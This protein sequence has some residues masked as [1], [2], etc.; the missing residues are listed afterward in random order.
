MP[1]LL[2][3][4]R[5][6]LEDEIDVAKQVASNS[7]LPLSNGHR[8]GE[9]GK[10]YQYAFLIDT[11]LN[12]PDGAPGELVLPGKPPFPVTIVSVEGLRI[13]ISVE[14]D[15]GQFVPNA[16]LQ[17]NLA[18]LM[19]R[20]IE[21]IE[22]RAL[23]ENPAGRRM[24]GLE[25]VSG[26]PADLHAF[27]NLNDEQRQALAS[28]LGRNLTVIWGP[29]GTGKTHTIGT[30]VEQ[31]F[32]A[33]RTVLVVSHTNTAVDQAI[34]HVAKSMASQLREGKVIRVGDIR[35][36]ELRANYPDVHIKYQVERQSRELVRQREL[37]TVL[38]D[39][40][41]DDLER[42][43]AKLNL[44]DW[45]KGAV[46][47]IRT[48][49]RAVAEFAELETQLA[50][51]RKQLEALQTEH[52]D[53]LQLQGIANLILEFRA[54]LAVKRTEQL[55]LSTELS[56][57]EPRLSTAQ[58]ALREQQ[59][60]R[61]IA[62]R[63]A[64]LKTEKTAYPTAS[65]QEAAIGV[66]SLKLAQADE[67]LEL[68]KVQRDEVIALLAQ[69]SNMVGF[70]RFLRGLPPPDELKSKAADLANKTTALEAEKLA[71]KRAFWYTSQKLGRIYELDAEL[72]SHSDIDTPATEAARAQTAEA[73]VRD[74]EQRK[75][76][77]ENRLRVVNSELTRLETEICRHASVLSDDPMD[78][79]ATVSAKLRLLRDL[80]AS[81]RHLSARANSLRQTTL[82][83]L[84]QLFD[85]TRQWMDMERV[86]AD[87]HTLLEAVIDC[88]SRLAEEVS[89]H[90]VSGLQTEVTTLRAQMNQAESSIAEID[91]KLSQIEHTLIMNA[92]VLGATLTKVYLSDDIQARKFDTVILDEASMAPIPALWAAALLAEHSLIIVGDFRQL[93]PIVLSEKPGTRKWLGRDIFEASGLKQEYE[94]RT[95]PANFIPLREQRRMLP[96]IARI[97]NRFYDGIL[98]TPHTP[99]N[100]LEAFHDW[101][102][103]K[104]P[105]DNQVVLVNTA[106]LHAWVT[107]VEQ[108]HKH[109]R[110]NFLSAT[111]TVD[112]AEQLFNP[113]CHQRDAGAP[114]RIMIIAPYRPHARLV[115]L[116]IKES[117][118]LRDEA[119]S[120]TVHSFQGSQAHVVIFDLVADE[121]H[122]RVN[123]FTPSVDDDMKRL[124]NVA[125]T[126]A[127]FRLFIVGDFSYCSKQGRK[128]F[129]GRDL[130][131]FLLD[132]FPLVDAADLIPNGLAARAAHAQITILGGPIENVSDRLM[133]TQSS[134]FR[135]LS[136]DISS[137]QSR[138][139]IYSPFMT[140]DRI[141]FLLP[142]LQAA[143]AQGVNIYV[144]TKSH[145]ERS[146]S[147]LD[148]IRQLETQLQ[149]AGAVVMHKMRMHEKLV[150]VDTDIVWVGSLNTLSHSNTQEIMERR[151]SRAVFEDYVRLLRLDHLLAVPGTEAS[152]CPICG[153]EMVAAE[154]ADQPFYW[155]CVN[156]NCYTRSIDQP[157]PTNG[158]LSCAKCGAA[159]E[160]GYWGGDP[161]WRCT[162]NSRHRQRI[163]RSHLRL[164]KM[165][166][167]IP[168]AERRKVYKLLGIQPEERKRPQSAGGASTNRTQ[169]LSLFDEFS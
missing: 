17:T 151:Q 29:P 143:S 77:V 49:E 130:I 101:Y 32:G 165:A 157:Y 47:T 131:P 155:R 91:R 140:A 168:R 64:P 21:R 116:L 124:L 57:L 105:H 121:P 128:A 123:L 88:H 20:L 110:L 111:A 86:G 160:F 79:Q 149:E 158:E 24:L 108:G 97:A 40:F 54:S 107:T 117:N 70:L 90:D 95:P 1:P 39:T 137:A 27:P 6:A 4:F 112:L 14:S 163:F 25:R 10:A 114:Q 15:L 65:E 11:V 113:N 153:A 120:G 84:E 74:L 118:R 73:E 87:A 83:I 26:S 115:S 71:L 150:M 7:A 154:G 60:R 34:K 100:G 109:S 53:L 161:H 81:I 72:S 119:V 85:Q 59:A 52:S 141:A 133:T 28:S 41:G 67:R 104:W 76:Q 42:V 99:P 9:Q 75:T 132:N 66:L 43:Q 2:A 126:R 156:D 18:F 129:L 94:N 45:V 92:V 147:E 148:G 33:S 166:S 58:Q 122:R 169:Q 46:H 12:A 30:I 8:V 102:N 98:K 48:C 68:L 19:R 134:F 51:E 35:D 127:Q 62:V 103:F 23:E 56:E 142:Q 13:L 135:L 22:N 136:A 82:P 55:S 37:L 93:P 78:I 61:D 89:S 63:I 50:E 152:H 138:I 31:L 80:P 145:S 96:D 146:K 44:I 3:E 162:E 167:L 5:A 164:P 106:S 144:I 139:I 36:E 125:L 159:Y 69:V 16:R 38:V